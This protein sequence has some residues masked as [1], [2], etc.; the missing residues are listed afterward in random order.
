MAA[1]L[2]NKFWL[3][4]SSHGANPKYENAEQLWDACSQYFEWVESNPLYKTEAYAFQGVVTQE[5][6]PVMRAMTISG[7]CLFIG[8]DQTTWSDYRARED[9][10]RVAS[11]ADQIIRDQKFAGAAAGLLNANIIARDLG[12]K[13]S[14]STEIMGKDGGPID[15]RWTI[16]VHDPKSE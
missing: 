11:M 5:P 15:S 10:S 12:L 13:D 14:S 2:G 9:L 16:E 8:I 4:R 6:V 7:L 1:P 3:A